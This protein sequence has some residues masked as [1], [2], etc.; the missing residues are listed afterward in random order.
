MIKSPPGDLPAVA[1][2]QWSISNGTISGSVQ[3][4]IATGTPPNETVA[5]QTD[6]VTGAVHGSSVMV[7]FDNR[8]PIFGTLSGDTL[9]LNGPLPDGTIEASAWHKATTAEYDQAVAQL[10]ATVDSANQAAIRAAQAAAQAAQI[11]KEQEAIDSDV[12]AVNNDLA[13]L[14]SHSGQQDIAAV[15]T[16]LQQEQSDFAKT[17]TLTQTVLAQARQDPNDSTGQVCSNAGKTDSQAG[18]VAFSDT[19]AVGSAADK[20]GNDISSSRKWVQ[21]I[22]GDFAKLQFDEA[23]LPSYQP[24][25]APTAQQVTDAVNGEN[26]AI[27][28]A[29]ST[30]NAEID[31]ANADAATAMQLANQ[32]LASVKDCGVDRTPPTA[33]QHLSS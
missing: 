24:P 12:T 14:S 26:A 27:A 32:A 1:Y 19:G 21:Q 11:Q 3:E 29:L 15:G 5:G 30:V 4:A 10:H 13:T 17:Q 33:L 20:V 7:Q 8:P 22:Q 16:A 18:T 23:V 9:T 6:S 31:T 25:G 28:A 2:I